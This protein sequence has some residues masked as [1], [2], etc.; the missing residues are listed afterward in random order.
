V[1]LQSPV[2]LDSS[3][4]VPYG[5]ASI[6][7][8]HVR[9]RKFSFR[10][11]ESCDGYTLPSPRQREYALRA[12]SVTHFHWGDSVEAADRYAWYLHNSGY[13]PHSVAQKVPNAFGLYDMAGNVEEMTLADPAGAEDIYYAKSGSAWSTAQN[14]SSSLRT[15]PLDKVTV[16]GST[17]FRCVRNVVNENGY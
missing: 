2:H 13:R 4:F 8:I 6:E 17:G 7:R 15:A 16:S 9:I 3:R 11:L 1:Y 12:E 10:R 14:L 5:S